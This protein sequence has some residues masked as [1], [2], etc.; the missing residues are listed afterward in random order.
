MSAI[1]L[2]KVPEKVLLF[3]FV[4]VFVC[5]CVCVCAG[6]SIV[7]CVYSKSLEFGGKLHYRNHYPVS[8]LLVLVS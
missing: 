3:V 1:Y 6:K 4:F 2:L 5:V 7:V 8:C